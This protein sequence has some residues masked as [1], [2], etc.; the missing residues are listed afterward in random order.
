MC[1]VFQS[2]LPHKRLSMPAWKAPT[3]TSMPQ[4][5]FGKQLRTAHMGRINTSMKPFFVAKNDGPV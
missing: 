1:E 4:P 3:V 2:R 5:G